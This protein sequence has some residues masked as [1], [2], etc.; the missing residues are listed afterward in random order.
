MSEKLTFSMLR[1]DDLNHHTI[2]EDNFMKIKSIYFVVFTLLFTIVG[3]E[4]EKSEKSNFIG[5]EKYYVIK[6]EKRIFY[7]VIGDYV[8][9]LDT[10]QTYEAVTKRLKENSE[11]IFIRLL[12]ENHY[13]FHV[14][15]KLSLQEVKNQPDVINAM[16]TYIQKP[17][18][19]N[20]P[21]YFM[22]ELILELNEGYSIADVQYL[23]EN[24]VSVVG[25]KY[26]YLLQVLDWKRIFEI[27]T[28]LNA[29]EKVKFCEPNMFANFSLF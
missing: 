27:V 22:G 21:V 29:N 24:Q 19:V 20:R 16:P 9:Q 12:H 14:G 28:M 6:G 18:E 25:N 7:E 2:K 5:A 1:F 8:V 13:L 4:K 3:C 10:A 23:I 17:F 11:F 15:S 26:S